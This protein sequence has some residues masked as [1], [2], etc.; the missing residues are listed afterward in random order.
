MLYLYMAHTSSPD[1]TASAPAAPILA[2]LWSQSLNEQKTTIL[3][4]IWTRGTFIFSWT[5]QKAYQY[6]TLSEIISQSWELG[7]GLDADI[8]PCD[9]NALA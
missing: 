8:L 1:Q 5:S 9:Y 6:T 4:K 3:L 7:L 2:L